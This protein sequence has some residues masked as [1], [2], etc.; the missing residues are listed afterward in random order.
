ME[1]DKRLVM[2]DYKNC[3]ANIPNSVLKHFGVPPVGNTLPQMDRLL[4]EK[5]YRNV[6]LLLLDGMGTY[7]L[8]ESLAEGGFFRSHMQESISSVFLAT[9]VAA[10][11]SAISGLQP[12]EHSWL[13]WDCYYPSVDKNVTVFL[14]TIQN[15]ETPAADYNIARSVTPY[16]S[17]VDK[18]NK[19]GGQAYNAFP[20][21]PP[22]PQTLEDICG[23]IKALC[24]EEGKKYIYAYWNEPD[25]LIHSKGRRSEEVISLLRDMESLVEKTASALEDTLL[26]IT[27]DHGHMN[28]RRVYLKDYPE[29]ED[30]L[31]RNPSLEPRALNLFVKPGREREFEE[32]FNEAFGRDFVLITMEQALDMKLFGTGKEH[33]AFRSML[34]N[35]LAIA[36]ADL[37]IYFTDEYLLS[38]HGSLTPD[39]M[40]IPFIVCGQ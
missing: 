15:T 21:M 12:C 13:G 25:N 36:A 32:R 39:E 31:V 7:I 14:N 34:G 8:E 23:R 11:T 33:A 4:A 19:A 18:I 29:I 40:K 28:N 16:E 24:A 3:I 27:A 26:I 38:M 6:V 1:L 22:F 17:V 35:Y 9:T 20:F 30:C 37:S 5:D 10:T 2:P